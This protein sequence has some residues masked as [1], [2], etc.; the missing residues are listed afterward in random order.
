VDRAELERR[1]FIG[2]IPL[3]DI[4][5]SVV[6]KGPG[7]YAVECPSSKPP[8]WPE[9]SCGGWL[10]GDPA[11]PF[12]ELEA[13]WVDGADIAYL[14]Q[15]KGLRRRLT[16]FSRFGAGKPVRHWGGRLVWQLPDPS[17]LRVGWFETP[18]E[19]PVSVEARFIAEFRSVFGKPPFANNPDR[20]GC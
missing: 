3:L 7:V 8:K 18:L 20:L 14:G 2:W 1:G 5:A 17:A 19:S 6:P 16:D 10:R 11:V 15:S 9:T 4:D 13:N 12:D